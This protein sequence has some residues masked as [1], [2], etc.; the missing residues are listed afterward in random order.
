[1]KEKFVLIFVCMKERRNNK[2]IK[3]QEVDK[4]DN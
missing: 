1:M 2:D 4:I 3:M